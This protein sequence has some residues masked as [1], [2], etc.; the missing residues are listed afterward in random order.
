MTGGVLR[1]ERVQTPGMGSG[2]SFEQFGFV[3]MK[4]FLASRIA[5]LIGVAPI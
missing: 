4:N 3:L 5:T 1:R 2:I